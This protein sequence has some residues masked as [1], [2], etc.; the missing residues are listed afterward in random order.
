MTL[1][2]R[3]ILSIYLGLSSGKERVFKFSL[4]SVTKED[5]LQTSHVAR[6]RVLAVHKE[7]E[8][9]NVWRCTEEI[10]IATV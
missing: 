6:N 8:H 5:S 4:Q 1:T 7:K 9:G 3:S 10:E 2:K